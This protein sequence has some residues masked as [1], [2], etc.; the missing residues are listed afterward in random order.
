MKADKTTNLYKV[1]IKDYKSLVTQN[2]TAE[3]KKSNAR[4]IMKVNEEAAEIA[5][6]LDI[7]DRVDN[8]MESDAFITIKDHK[9]TFPGKIEC[10]LLNPA[11]SNLGKVS[12]Q[13]LEEAVA[14]VRVKTKS[15]QWKNSNEVI[16]WFKTLHNKS[17]LNFVKFDVVS[18]HPSISQNLF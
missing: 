7:A 14:V 2:V 9:Q 12:N 17:S 10:R 13:I 6:K 3:Y 5:S 18:F 11:K 16:E 8:Y 1:P 4:E 15:N